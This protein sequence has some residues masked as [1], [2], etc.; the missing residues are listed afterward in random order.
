VYANSASL[1]Y[2]LDCQ[3]LGLK[4]SHQPLSS[5][6]H[7]LL[8]TRFSFIKAACSNS[9]YFLFI[10]FISN[11]LAAAMRVVSRTSK[12]GPFPAAALIFSP[13]DLLRCY[14][15][16]Q[17]PTNTCVRDQSHNCSLCFFLVFLNSQLVLSHG[18]IT[19]WSVSIIW[20]EDL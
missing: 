1:S 4:F 2:R 19:T 16:C 18:S 6:D 7:Y 15:S 8:I 13:D 9:S 14:H 3:T 5:I 20:K 12:A 17:G 11:S 10:I